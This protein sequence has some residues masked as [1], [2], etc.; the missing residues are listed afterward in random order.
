[1]PRGGL[2][3][4]LGRVGDI[5]ELFDTIPYRETIDRYAGCDRLRGSVTLPPEAFVAEYIYG[6]LGLTLETRTS[7]R[8]HPGRLRRSDPPDRVRWREY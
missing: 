3:R 6:A 7:R 4:E 8:S 2:R 1:M 5:F